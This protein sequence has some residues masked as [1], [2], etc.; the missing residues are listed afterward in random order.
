MAR[1]EAQKVLTSLRAS[2][3]RLYWVPGC[4][5]IEGNERATELSRKESKMFEEKMIE[6]MYAPQQEYFSNWKGDMELNTPWSWHY[7]CNVS[8]SC[9]SNATE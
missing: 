7:T 4:C 9:V 5:V 3:A 8:A 6:G 1:Y 2:F